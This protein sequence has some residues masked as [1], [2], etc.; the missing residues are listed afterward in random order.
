[1]MDLSSTVVAIFSIIKSDDEDLCRSRVDDEGVVAVAFLHRRGMTVPAVPALRT[2]LSK[3]VL[4]VLAVLEL[5]E[6]QIKCTLQ[7]HRKHLNL[8]G[9]KGVQPVWHI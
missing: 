1:M 9:L 2:V 8:G 6:M 5:L 7:R 4:T 3:P